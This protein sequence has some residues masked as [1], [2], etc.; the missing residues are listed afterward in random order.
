MTTPEWFEAG[1]N[2]KVGIKVGALSEPGD[3]GQTALAVRFAV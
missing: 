2:A 3:Q 1:M